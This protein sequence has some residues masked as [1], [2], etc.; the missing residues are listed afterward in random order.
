MIG[1]ISAVLMAGSTPVMNEADPEVVALR[2]RV[3]ADGHV[4]NATVRP[5]LEVAEHLLA[6]AG[7]GRGMA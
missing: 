7:L 3:Y 1:F 6:S 5:T 4:D 2:V